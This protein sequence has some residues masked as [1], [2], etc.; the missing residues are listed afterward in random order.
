V[1]STRPSVYSEHYHTFISLLSAD[2]CCSFCALLYVSFND[3]FHVEARTGRIKLEQLIQASDFR[4]K[5]KVG[6]SRGGSGGK[7]HS[8]AME[9]AD[10]D[11][12]IGG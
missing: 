11:S 9:D 8:S 5:L 3:Y 12:E 7:L 6:I 10:V 1:K 2:L 4:S